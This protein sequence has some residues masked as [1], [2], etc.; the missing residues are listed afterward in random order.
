MNVKP[1]IT[2][3]LAVLAMTCVGLARAGTDEKHKPEI[4]IP[5]APRFLYRAPAPEQFRPIH[6][7]GRPLDAIMDGL[8]VHLR[9]QFTPL[10]PSWVPMKDARQI[11]EERRRSA[12]A[13]D[14]VK[15]NRNR[16]V[17]LIRQPVDPALRDF[18][19]FVHE[20]AAN[21]R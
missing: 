4:M 16:G 11:L 17:I 8:S 10:R 1:N 9:K 5:A 15:V 13:P 2:L 19:Q 14:V 3:A 18:M 6:E 7:A 21:A 12:A 20:S